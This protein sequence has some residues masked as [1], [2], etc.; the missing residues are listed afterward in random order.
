MLP[1][2]NIYIKVMNPFSFGFQVRFKPELQIVYT[3][4]MLNK[5]NNLNKL[6]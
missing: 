2:Y 5:L 1:F 6:S 4:L 3:F